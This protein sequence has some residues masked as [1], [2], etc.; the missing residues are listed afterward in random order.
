MR[1]S[2]WSSDVCSSDLGERAGIITS[3]DISG[4]DEKFSRGFDD[5]VSIETIGSVKVGE[6]AR[7]AKA[8]RSKRAHAHAPYAAQP[9]QC[10]G[11]ANDQ[12]DQARAVSN[13]VQPDIDIN[14]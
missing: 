6:I 7:L 10:S 11:G 4:S 12:R 1:I 5:G 13:G 9:G 2:D 14:F 3:V 8:A